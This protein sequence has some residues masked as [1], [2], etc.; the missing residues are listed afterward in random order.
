MM[1]NDMIEDSLAKFTLSLDNAYR[2]TR[3]VPV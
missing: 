1:E 3:N 2:I